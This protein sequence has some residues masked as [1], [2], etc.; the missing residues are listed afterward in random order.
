MSIENLKTFG[1]FLPHLRVLST[2]R[3]ALELF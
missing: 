3:L 2:L 1:E